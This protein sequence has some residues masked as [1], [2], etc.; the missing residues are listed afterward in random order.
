[1]TKQEIKEEN[2]ITERE[3]LKI[4]D[5]VMYKGKEATIYA[6]E[7][8]RPL[9]D[10]GLAP[11]MY[12]LG[13]WEDVTPIKEKPLEAKDKDFKEVDNKNGD[14]K[15]SDHIAEK[16]QESV[17]VNKKVV[18]SHTE[19]NLFDSP[20]TESLTKKEGNESDPTLQD[21][22]RSRESHTGIRIGQK[23][24]PTSNNLES[25]TSVQDVARDSQSKR[26]RPDNGSGE[27][28]TRPKHDVNKK[29]SNEEIQEIVS[30]V[31]EVKDGKV[32]ITGDVTDDI[33]TIVRQYVS[34]GVAKQGRGVLDEYY[35][36]GKIVDAIGK[37]ILHLLPSGKRV[38][39]LEPSVGMGN[40]LSAVPATATSKVVTFEINDTTARIAKILHPD[41]DV[42]VRSF[43]TEFIDDEGNK[44][45]VQ[46]V[47]DVAIGNPPYGTHRGVYKGLGEEPNIS[48]YEDYFVKRSLDVLS[49]GGL[50]AMVLPSSWLDRQKKSK[51]YDLVRAYR[52]PSGA[53]AGTSV[54][55]DIIILKKNSNAATIDIS[56]Y[57]ED[58][59]QR[60][61]GVEKERFGRFGR[62]E[63]YVE[64]D[65]D[66][67]LDTI[68][69]DDAIDVANELSLPTDNDTL[70]SVE[71]AI[72]EAGSKSG[73]KKIVKEELKEVEASKRNNKT[74]TSK[75]S[76]SGIKRHLKKAG[77]VV[78]ASVHFDNDF[79]EEEVSAF[80]VTN[81]DGTISNWQ[82]H[83]AHVSYY[84]GVYMHDFY[85]AEGDIYAKLA[86][87]S[88][89]KEYIVAI[90]GQEQ[91]DKQ[92]KMLKDVLPK[93]KHIDEITLTPNTTFAHSLKMEDGSLVLDAFKDF[94][95]DLPYSTFGSSSAWEVVGYVN[96]EQVY[97]K[98]KE[99]NQLVRERRK[100]VGDALFKRFLK[101]E[102]NESQ[103]AIIET[104]FNREYNG[105]YRPDYSKVPMFSS[106][107]K[108][109]KGKELKLTTVQLAGVGRSTVKGVGVLAHEV[110]FGKTL[111]GVMAM[112]EAMTRGNAKRPL[113]VVPNDNIMQ[114]WIETIEE[115]I[116][117]ATINVLGNLGTKYDL[118]DFN[119]NDNEFSIVTY[120][121]LKAMSFNDETYTNLANEFSYITDE[122]QAHQSV[123]DAEKAKAKR[124]ELKGKLKKGAKKTYNF[125]SFGFDYLTFDEV[126]NANHIVGKVK[127]DKGEYSD[128]RSQSQ[129]TS[130]LGIKTWIAAQYIQKKNNGR[131]VL[132]LSATPFTNKP[133][134][135][136]SI[137]SLVAN[138]TLKR[139]GFYKID[140]FFKTF[141]EA[142]NELEIT[143]SGTP[144]RKTNVRRFRNN[145]LFQSLLSEY[146]DIK[147]EEDNPDLI[148]PDRHNKEYKLP[149]NEKTKAAMA[150]VQD[151]LNDSDTLLQGIGYARQVAFTPYA[152][153]SMTSD[154]KAFVENSPKI[155][156]T[157]K[158]IAQNKKDAPNTGQIIYSEVCV[159]TFPMIREYLI[160]ETGYKESEVRIITGATS[161][162]ERVKIQE[163][164]NTGEVKV[165][166]GSPAIKEGLN[167]QGNT[168][169]MYILSLPWN[170]TQLR[171]IEGRG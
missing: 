34:G 78:P 61:L 150:E 41:I 19:G 55:T 132:L 117:E 73:G 134:E 149:Q 23:E 105:T 88:R 44:K 93:F 114:Q 56:H 166:I 84:N 70:N 24:L 161:N 147:G 115:A 127:L 107:R 54:G 59:P 158:L 74:S 89:D 167:L 65:I 143:A 40:F 47:Y 170:F 96:N 32:I 130:D 94:L 101:E 62:V 131:N 42:N 46:Q 7:E 52:L 87:L 26:L 36:D 102:L 9:L 53:F 133:L 124:S 135:Y 120:E 31:T 92:Y 111:S 90:H 35:T 165:V 69:R 116:P 60:V 63:K 146:I 79:S 145:G 110:G 157:I 155:D 37:L 100:K 159:D 108:D 22:D 29:Y 33:R 141:M 85:Y 125:E 83:K 10:T 140:E 38:R 164:F 76:G 123:R 16:E 139:K 126:H 160:K 148:R 151:M 91:Y 17:G 119:V 45:P 71:T 153:G 4:G 27:F 129:R 163:A 18:S 122:L 77:D 106:V 72:E 86:Q 95:H 152:I 30:S 51:N 3:G 137:L 11:V 58:H 144:Q 156:A 48:R 81:Y 103:R 162:N 169:D 171:Q 13:R 121:G 25:R 97:G 98:D 118:T 1:H 142:D 57:F 50:L 15:L 21:N 66:T 6:I 128:F 12:E 80:K 8:D 64:G 104:A 14:T 112:H 99:Y 20:P 82:D 113:I 109:F 67:A 28:G 75:A 68:G 43:E 138:E 5:K 2:A 154:Y 168:T 49:D 136:Y 39:V